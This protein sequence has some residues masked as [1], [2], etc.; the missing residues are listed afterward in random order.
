MDAYKNTLFIS[1]LLVC[2]TLNVFLTKYQ[3]TICIEN[4]NKSQ[5]EYVYFNQPM[6]QT[7]NMFIGEILCLIIFYFNKNETCIQLNEMGTENEQLF[8]IE[9]TDTY[10]ENDIDEIESKN[11]ILLLFPALC[12]SLSSTLMNIGLIFVSVSM[13]QMLR[14]SIVI[15][16]AIISVLFLNQTYNLKKWSSLFIIFLGLVIVGLTGPSHKI[17]TNFIGICL[18]LL[19][20]IFTATQYV[21]EEKI[22]LK[23]NVSPL[24]VVGIEG[25]FG[26]IIISS[27]IIICELSN[28]NFGSKDSI[29]TGIYQL[30]YPQIYIPSVIIIFSISLF[31]WFGLNITKN[32]S[33]TSRATI[34]I[35]RTVLIWSISL[36][37]KMEIFMWLQAV[38]FIVMISGIMLFNLNRV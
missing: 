8:E 9:S 37:L 11:Y 25:F 16:T 3:D 24:F 18:I 31:N 10:Y 35:S 28:F 27:L 22:L 7:L 30:S 17:D 1:G 26:T 36:L 12:D 38:G 19:A 32:I 15:F 20:Q 21:L 6:L 5:Q 4:C 2:G 33:S 29:L 14:G 34:D 13:Y 23:Y